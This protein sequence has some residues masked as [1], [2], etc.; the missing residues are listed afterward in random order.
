MLNLREDGHSVLEAGELN[1]E[2]EVEAASLI[3]DLSDTDR[4]KGLALDVA[5]PSLVGG[6]KEGEAKRS[7]SLKLKMKLT[8][9]GSE[10]VELSR[11]D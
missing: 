3:V 7:P 11:F 6:E 9:L 1:S 10:L 4:G 8:G 2:V 5:V